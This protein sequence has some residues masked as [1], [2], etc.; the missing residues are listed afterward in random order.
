MIPCW[1]STWISL[2][3]SCASIPRPRSAF[4]APPDPCRAKTEL[5]EPSVLP[6]PVPLGHLPAPAVGL[7]S[8]ESVPQERR[9]GPTLTVPKEESLL[10]PTRGRQGRATRHRGGAHL[11]SVTFEYVAFGG[12]TA[13]HHVFECATVLVTPW[14]TSALLNDTVEDHVAWPFF[15]LLAFIWHLLHSTQ[16]PGVSCR[17]CQMVA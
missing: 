17:P 13:W 14:P 1:G 11:P 3:G 10:A 2:L 7:R 15:P 6:R 9:A 16:R 4:E 8:L 5:E 12:G